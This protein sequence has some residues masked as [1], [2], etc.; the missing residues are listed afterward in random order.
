LLENGYAFVKEEFRNSVLGQKYSA[1]ESQAKSK[2][3]GLHK[4]DVGSRRFEDLT[5]PPVSK[6]HTE[7]YVQRR[8]E[9]LSR[10]SEIEEV[11]V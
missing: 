6:A 5:L 8:L 11:V 7:S 9:V 10:L 3:K 2:L 1:L 4:K